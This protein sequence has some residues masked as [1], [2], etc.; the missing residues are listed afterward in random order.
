MK[1]II[2]TKNFELSPV[3]KSFTENRVQKL[4]KFI[5]ILKNDFKEILVELARETKHHRKG[6]IFRAELIINLPGKNLIAI[7]HGENLNKAIVAAKDEMEIEIKKYKLK[8][9]ELPR[10]KMRK[11]NP[12]VSY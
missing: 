12:E 4:E 10:R 2:K 1:I 8:K 5:K 3:L 6:D 11:T 7:S 9:I